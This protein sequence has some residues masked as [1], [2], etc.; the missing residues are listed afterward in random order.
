MKIMQRTLG[1]NFPSDAIPFVRVWAPYVRSLS[2]LPQGKPPV[3][4][5]KD[6]SGYWHAACPDLKPGDRYLLQINGKKNLPDPASLSQPEGVKHASE[7]I[8]LSE[9]RK[10]RNETWKG[11]A[12]KD[13]IIYELHTAAF[14]PGGT[15]RSM[16][17]KLPYLR[18]LGVNAINIMPVASFPGTRN[19]GYDGVFPYAVQHSYGGPEAFVHLVKA[20]HQEGI[21]VILDVV[22][23]HFGPEGNCFDA[24]GPYVTG[25][26][27]TPWGRAI[28]FDDADCEGVRQFF[29]ENALMWLRDFH[30]D[31][32]RLDAVHTIKDF[33]PRHFLR[34]LSEHVQELNRATDARHF[35]IGENEGNDS[36]YIRPVSEGGYG[37]DAQWCDDW[38]HSLHALLTGERGGYYADY[39]STEHLL[40]AFN[41]A[42]VQQ[43][44][45]L[46][47][48]Q[49]QKSASLIPD[50]PGHRY[51]VYT[52]NHDQVG[53]RPLG[54]RLSTLLDFESLKLAA[55]ALFVSPFLPMLFMGEEYAEENPFFYFI[56]HEDKSLTD[57]IKR[58][59]KREFH[60]FFK[61]GEPP[62]IASEATFL[63][64]KLTWNESGD[65]SKQLM[66]SFYQRLIAI[67]KEQA[68][69]KPGL[70]NEIH[71]ASTPCS[72]GIILSRSE[73]NE[74]LI[75]LMNF[76]EQS[77]AIELPGVSAARA[78]LLINSAHKKWGGILHDMTISFRQN[79][80]FCTMVLE[81][82]SILIFRL[83]QAYKS[84]S[85][86]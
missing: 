37:L 64:S 67:R 27:K 79:D 54:E 56:N 84:A 66:L 55:G 47:S 36:R 42:C 53:N 72:R 74:S 85:I 60:D 50:Q 19:W 22:Y 69:L 71:A 6:A 78:E 31:G 46:A 76:S 1:V 24:Y 5:Q 80:H 20:C 48:P 3:I 70:R 33:S 39:G 58:G 81:K 62:D 15:F 30:V 41:H 73:G 83:N 29:I 49:K 77:L 34:E 75:A 7:C 43:D 13:L 16:Q 2:L 32:L 4:L 51:V 26:Y 82:K 21:A 10:I 18:T 44:N 61:H 68:L 25:K 17:E 38:H 65:A 59:R 45:P 11:I 63:K 9:I 57:R 28:N 8:D 52:Q 35:L 40:H 86:T 23:N 14:T 12:V